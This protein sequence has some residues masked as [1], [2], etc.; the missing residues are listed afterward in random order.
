MDD[1]RE[2]IECL[3]NSPQRLKILDALD[4]A[5]MDVREVMAALD[6][7][8]STVQRNLSVL[9]DRGWVEATGS[10]YT[11]TTV[12]ELLRAEFMGM[13]ETA[14]KIERMAPFLNTVDA[15]A[16]VAVDQLNDVLVTTQPLRSGRPGLG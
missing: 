16:E 13:G 9:E 12:G 6:S 3:C 5:R 15:P 11:A 2:T 1:L 4:G 7:P 8:R 10:G 14:T